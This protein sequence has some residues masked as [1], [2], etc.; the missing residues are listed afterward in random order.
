MTSSWVIFAPMGWEKLTFQR[1][2]PSLFESTTCRI[3]KLYQRQKMPHRPEEPPLFVL[4]KL[5]VGL[6][7]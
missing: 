2:R 4:L 1:K 3:A 5:Q 6:S 7:L